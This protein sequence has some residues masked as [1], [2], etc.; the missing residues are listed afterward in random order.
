MII[1]DIDGCIFDNIHRAHLIPENRGHTPSWSV[2]N[3]ACGGDRPVL[4]IINLVKYQAKM[5]AHD[6][7]RKITFVTSR[8]EDS[9]RE[10]ALQLA[11]YFIAYDCTL[12]MRKMNDHRS[13]VDY[14]REK[15]NELSGQITEGS[16][17]I[18]DHPGIIKMVGINF[19]QAQ[20]LL[21]Q[22]FDC[23]VLGR[24]VAA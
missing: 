19:P 17:I 22:S 1:C 3:K 21:V 16:L 10:T 12:I 24:E 11:A 20:R 7:H 2:F 8:A 18:D 6:L 14:K 9:R 15:F 4:P 23:T 13:T 5:A